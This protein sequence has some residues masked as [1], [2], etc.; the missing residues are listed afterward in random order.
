M[1]EAKEAAGDAAAGANDVAAA[2]ATMAGVVAGVALFTGGAGGGIAIALTVG[3]GVAWWIANEYS[4]LAADPP[5]YDYHLVSRFR[6]R[7]IEFPPAKSDI[8]AVLNE[9]SRTQIEIADAI[10]DLTTSFERLDGAR[11]D[12]RKPGANL[13]LLA[14]R[15]AA[16]RRAIKHNA[17]AAELRIQALLKSQERINAAW[18]AYAEG[19]DA[20]EKRLPLHERKQA[21]TSLWPQIMPS[22]RSILRDNDQLLNN[23]RSMLEQATVTNLDMPMP[24]EVLDSQWNAAM[25]KMVRRL[26]VFAGNQGKFSAA[27]PRDRAV[28][29]GLR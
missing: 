7:N 14:R 24:N 19:P 5:R 29:L 9:L 8:E 18:Q 13:D 1:L 15:I 23:I 26:R 6:V 17:A 25:H 21:L 4:D 22:L 11:I 3:S 16:Q 2:L 12:L 20:T 28:E 10:A 27:N